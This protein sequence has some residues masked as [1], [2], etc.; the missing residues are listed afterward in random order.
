MMRLF[1]NGVELE[2][3][4]VVH[5]TRAVGVLWAVRFLRLDSI[6]WSLILL[7]LVGPLLINLNLL[8]PQLVVSFSIVGQLLL[9]M[10]VLLLSMVGE[11]VLV[12]LDL[13]GSSLPVHT[14]E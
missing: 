4:H 3:I 12:L 10:L 13:L 8:Q 5:E 14:V 2:L 7:V 11:D 1:L 9:D 6:N